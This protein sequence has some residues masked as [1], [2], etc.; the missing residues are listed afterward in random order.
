MKNFRSG[1]RVII[2][3]RQQ[4]SV[5]RNRY[6]ATIVADLGSEYLV[7]IGRWWWKRLIAVKPSEI[8]SCEDALLDKAVEA[9]SA[10]E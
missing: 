1:E 10:P 4:Y 5:F 9:N 2:A 3:P 7:Q 6:E 8:F